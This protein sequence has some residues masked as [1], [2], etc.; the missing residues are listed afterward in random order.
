VRTGRRIVPSAFFGGL[1][2]KR[3]F[4]TWSSSC[5]M[6]KASLRKRHTPLSLASSPSYQFKCV[7]PRRLSS[8]FNSGAD[9]PG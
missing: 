9:F 4:W 7:L 5:R 1:R 2:T 3:H 6:R 8:G